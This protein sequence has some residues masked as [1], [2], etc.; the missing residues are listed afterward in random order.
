MHVSNQ[1]E[2]RIQTEVDK[3]NSPI[4]ISSINTEFP[5]RLTLFWASILI[6]E[7]IKRQHDTENKRVL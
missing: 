5:F 4:F 7:N 1:M 2:V 6:Y 3:A